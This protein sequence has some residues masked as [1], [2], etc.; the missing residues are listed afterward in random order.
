MWTEDGLTSESDQPI[1][2][3][4]VI[5]AYNEA[6]RLPATLDAIRAYAARS[7]DAI[8]V[9]VIDDGSRDDTSSVARA[10]GI[11]WPLL[12]VEHDEQ[13]RGK[14]DAVRRGIELA[15]GEIVLFFDADSSTPIEEIEKFRPHFDA[16]ADI[17]IGSRALPDSDIRVRQ[18]W[19]REN[20]G[21]VFNVFVQAFVMR[22]VI[23]TQCG[24]KAF[25]REAARRICALQRLAGFAFDVELLF[26]ARKLGYQIREVPI[27]WQNS[28][29]SR[30]NPLWDSSR[31]FLDLLRIRWNDSR[32]RYRALG[33]RN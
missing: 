32:G 26:I 1:R 16:G 10:K 13:N 33:E 9:L 7:N 30:V 14:G 8:E 4:V 11:D 19:Y 5:P 2:L 18:P 12:R 23:D 27:V 15:R 17:V 25:R 31:M 29:K 3:S 22:G 24:F 28:A 6:E 21:R 20:M